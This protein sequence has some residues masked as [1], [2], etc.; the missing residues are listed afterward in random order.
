ME[1]LSLLEKLDIDPAVREALIA[2]IQSDY[3]RLEKR[4]QHDR[5]IIEKLKLELAY[6]RR[7]RFGQKS[8]GLKGEQQDI[9]NDA[10]A[11]DIGNI[12]EQIDSLSSDPEE[13]KTR[14]A[15]ERAGRQPLPEH[16][17]RVEH[18]HD[19]GSCACGQCG[20]DLVKIGEDITEQLDV[21]PAKFTVHRHIRPQYACRQ[22][23]TVTA[24]PVA[25]CY[26]PV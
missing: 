22:C 3:E 17:P 18:L 8:E 2:G 21:E 4:I 16:L 9:F 6:L 26:V 20:Q 23:E 5:F 14:K 10:L 11:E 12:A 1:A 7:I 13:T 15:R 24:V 19:L 25:P